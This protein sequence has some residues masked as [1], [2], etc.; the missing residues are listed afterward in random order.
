MI[1]SMAFPNILGAAL[2]S[3][4]IRRALDDYWHRLKT[5]EIKTSAEMQKGIES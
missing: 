5:G 2:L 1:L 4:K 3:G